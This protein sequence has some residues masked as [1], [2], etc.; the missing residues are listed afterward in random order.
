LLNVSDM[1]GVGN[2]IPKLCL[3]F[4]AIGMI[5]RVYYSLYKIKKK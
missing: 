5:S 1:I 2:E 3:L 4:I